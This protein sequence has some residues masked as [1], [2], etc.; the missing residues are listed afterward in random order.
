MTRL[1]LARHGETDWNRA[2]R[3]Q[4]QASVPLNGTGRAQAAR[5]ADVLEHIAYDALYSSDLPRALQT[6]QIIDAQA[7]RTDARLR[8]PYYGQFEGLTYDEM[9]ALAPAVYHK[10]QRDRSTPPPG[11]EPIPDIVERAASFLRDM[12]AWHPAQTVLVISHGELLQVLLCTALDRPI[13]DFRQFPLHN[14]T[15]TELH[16]TGDTA[17]LVRLNATP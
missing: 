4:G 3:Y 7:T 14:A 12:R 16:L 10:W 6:A 2:G 1:L 17:D 13:A 5:L 9:A 8:E 11:G 15:L